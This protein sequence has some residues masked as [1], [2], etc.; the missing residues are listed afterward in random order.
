MPSSQ[1]TSL[2]SKSEALFRRVERILP[3]VTKPGRYVGGEL[4]QVVKPWESVQTHVALVFPDIYD[5]GQSNL[6]IAL[7]YDILNAQEGVAAERAFSP[8]LDMEAALRENDIPLYS[9][10][11]KRAL[12]DFDIL[13]ISLPYETLYTNFLNIL[14]LAHLPLRS[15][16]RNNSHPLIVAGGQSVFNPEP[17]APFVDAFVIGEGEEAILDVVQAHQAWRESGGSREALLA[18][19]AAIPGVYIPSLYEVAYQPNGTV[20]SVTPSHPNAALPVQKRITAKLPPPL[21]HFLVPNVEVVQERVSVEIMRGCTRGCRFCHAGMVNRPIRERP[22]DEIL[23]TLKAGLDQTGYE[24]VSLLSLS[25]SDYSQIIPLING[26]R[27]LLQERQV[28]ITLPSL[29]IESFTEDL[30]DELQSLS[31]GGGFTL[32]PEAGTERLRAVINKPISD[33][34][35]MATVRSVYQ[36]GWN[37]IKLYFMIGHPQET[38]EDVAAIAELCKAVLNEGRR[39]VGGRARVHAGISTFIPK[40]HTPFQ[41][42]GF[43]SLESIQ[44]KLDILHQGLHGAKVKMTWNNPDSSLLEAWL[45]RGDRRLSEVI[46]RAWQK[47]ARFDAWSDQFNPVH[48]QAAFAEVGLDPDF[49]SHR[50]RG[51]D[52]VLPW[53]HIQAGVK[54]SFLK[55]DYQWSLR[56]Q[57]RPDCR[58]GCYSCGILSAY[59]ELRLVAPDG[60]WK[61]P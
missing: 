29:R 23:A 30:M 45:A 27:E 48:W 40:P 3:T 34:E 7:L 24:E 58:G 17:V 31:P 20:A 56:G 36:H 49:Y 60:G 59:N 43:D 44:Q 10:E 50:A 53:D 57:T 28:N 2:S 21:T 55:A 8:W 13:G 52:E 9:L 32:A 61:C 39:I 46:L 33:E 12:A 25:S 14:D 1:S 35:F 51:L 22:L 42:V 5:L 15:A 18:A 16:D 6:G 38:L 47:G 41:W 37:S 19:L 26:L 54:K 4:N 11:N